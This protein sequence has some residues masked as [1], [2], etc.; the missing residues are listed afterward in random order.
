[1]SFLL[2]PFF[3]EV[4]S[5]YHEAACHLLFS[6]F[7]PVSSRSGGVDRTVEGVPEDLKRGE[8]EEQEGRG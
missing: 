2:V 7:F 4:F 5:R 6:P 1:M 8:A 3:E